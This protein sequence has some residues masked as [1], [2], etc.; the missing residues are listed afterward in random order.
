MSPLLVFLTDG[1]ANIAADGTPGRPKA[2]SDAEAAA[3]VLASSSMTA[4]VLD[5]APRPRADAS[6][7]AAAMQAK[8]LPLPLA[9]AKA[10]KT[11]VENARPGRTAA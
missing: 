8:Y 1:S 6:N 5:I 3:K 7:L 4:L 10:L 11:A 9:D 2:K